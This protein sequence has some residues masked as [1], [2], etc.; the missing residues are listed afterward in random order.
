MWWTQPF[1][2]TVEETLLPDHRRWSRDK[3]E[4]EIVRRRVF[5]IVAVFLGSALAT[6]LALSAG[7]WFL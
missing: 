7:H 5:P 1:K 3:E 6:V 4:V 2:F